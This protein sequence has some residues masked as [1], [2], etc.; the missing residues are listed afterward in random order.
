MAVWRDL[1]WAQLRV[2]FAS[3]D[4]G[5]IGIAVLATLQTYLDPRVAMAALLRPLGD[6]PF[7]PAFRTTVIGFT[8][9]FLLPARVGEV[10]RPYLLARQGTEFFPP[11]LPRSS[12]NARWI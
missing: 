8:A 4:L 11:R 7:G 10:L 12:S 6:V 1:D 3:A 2:A 9:L 5:L